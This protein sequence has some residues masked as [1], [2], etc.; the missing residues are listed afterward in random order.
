[1]SLSKTNLSSEYCT[2]FEW[3][4]MVSTR[5]NALVKGAEQKLKKQDTQNLTYEQIAEI[6][7]YKQLIPYQLK[8]PIGNEDEYEILNIEE[9]IIPPE[10][11]TV[12]QNILERFN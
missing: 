2:K 1:M 11:V 9:A 3:T 5:L 8:R 10:F 6:E 7:V 4:E 12:P